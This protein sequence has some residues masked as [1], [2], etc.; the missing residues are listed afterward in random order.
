[1]ALRTNRGRTDR[2]RTE[3]DR[4][5]LFGVIERLRL[6]GSGSAGRKSRPRLRGRAVLAAATAASLLTVTGCGAAQFNGVSDMALPGGAD[7]GAHPYKVRAQFRDV[8]DLVPNSG[9]RVN[10]VPVGR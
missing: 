1:M 3:N 8:L 10:D 2:G 6:P 9:V 4:G 7:L 5:A